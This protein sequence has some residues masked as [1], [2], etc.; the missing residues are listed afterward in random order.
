VSRIGETSIGVEYEIT[1][2]ATS[3]GTAT[4]YARG[5]S[6]IVMVDYGTMQK[7]R[8]PDPVRAAIATL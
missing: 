1:D 4:V 8:V 6:V 2:A 5:S 3:D 7:V